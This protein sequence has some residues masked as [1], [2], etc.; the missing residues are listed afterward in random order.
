MNTGATGIF[1][2]VP[3]ANLQDIDAGAYD[4]STFPVEW[5]SFEAKQEGEKAAISWATA[6][7]TERIAF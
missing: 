5:V 6:V 1:T 2:P 7:E 3:G 4:P